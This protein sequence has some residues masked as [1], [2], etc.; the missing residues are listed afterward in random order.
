MLRPGRIDLVVEFTYCTQEQIFDY[1]KLF[2]PNCKDEIALQLAKSLKKK[3]ITISL[4]ASLPWQH[5]QC[6]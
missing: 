4:T 1:T 3:K 5:K 2:Y 6:K